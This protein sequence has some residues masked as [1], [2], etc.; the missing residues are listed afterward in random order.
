MKNFVSTHL[1]VAAECEP[2]KP[3]SKRTVPKESETVS[4][5]RNNFFKIFI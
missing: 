1:E 2:T 5:K 4:E 3:K